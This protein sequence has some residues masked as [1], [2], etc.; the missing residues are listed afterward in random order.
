LV[1]TGGSRSERPRVAAAQIKQ[2][3]EFLARVS[4]SNPDRTE[5][6]F[7]TLPRPMGKATKVVITEFDLPR[8][9]ALP[10][11]VVVDP[12]G[13]AWYSD[14]GAQMVGELDPKT[15][16]VRDY[17]IPTYRPEQPKGSLDL[18]LDPDGNLWV[19]MAYQAGAAMIDRKTKAVTPY[20]LNK[21]WVN[22]TSQTNQVTPTFMNVDGKVWLKDSDTRNTY[23][24]DINSGKWEN[25]GRATDQRLRHP[26]GQGQQRLHAGVQ[27]H[28]HRPD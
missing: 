5:Y 8:K 22:I 24:L 14:F 7:K 2:A 16:Q 1:V 10:H 27:Q 4:L 23:R 18:E 15:G 9:E 13:H 6:E 17:E 12:D 20:P 25:L 11:D 21:E 26:R 19:G 28:Q 3:A